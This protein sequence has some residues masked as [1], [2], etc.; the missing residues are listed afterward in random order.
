M[1]L[2]ALDDG[3]NDL[4]FILTLLGSFVSL[5]HHLDLLLLHSVL[6]HLRILANTHLI[7]GTLLCNTITDMASY[8]V[9]LLH[10]SKIGNVFHWHLCQ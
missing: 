4:H 5:T 9:E 2:T 7:T 10:V 8:N 6:A 3:H 1:R